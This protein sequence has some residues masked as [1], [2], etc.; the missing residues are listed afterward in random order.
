MSLLDNQGTQNPATKYIKFSGK[1]GKFGWYDKET[2]QN[3]ELDYPLSF[4]ALTDMPSVSGGYTDSQGNYV[5]IYSN[6]VNDLKNILTVKDQKNN[7]IARGIWADIKDTVKVNGGK[8]QINVYAIL[9]DE[10]VNFQFTGASLSAWINKSKGDMILVDE[11]KEEKK[12]A[13]VYYV[14]VFKSREL[15]GQESEAV[16]MSTHINQVKEYK[17]SLGNNVSYTET[18]EEIPTPEETKYE[19]SPF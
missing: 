9:K 11:T 12:G 5:S 13:V 8:F 2:K 19:D 15:T 18:V 3:N 17:A 10:L 4:I 16:M 6:M 7:Q 14:P 1:T